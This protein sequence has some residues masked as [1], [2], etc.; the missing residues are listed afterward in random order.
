M[1]LEDG[2]QTSN[3]KSF[4]GVFLFV[5]IYLF[6]SLCVEKTVYQ[7]CISCCVPLKEKVE[8]TLL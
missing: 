1:A 7:F 6:L 5:F 4:Y 3:N 8:T 2:T